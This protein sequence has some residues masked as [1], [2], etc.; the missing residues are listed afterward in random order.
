[1]KKFKQY[2]KEKEDPM[3]TNRKKVEAK[4]L[5]PTRSG[6]KGGSA[7]GTGPG[8]GSEDGSG[9]DGDGA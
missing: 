4:K 1:M 7:S 2:M 8:G 6:S 3:I 5:V 9:G